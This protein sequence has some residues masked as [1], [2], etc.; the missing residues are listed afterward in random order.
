[1]DENDVTMGV[2]LHPERTWRRGDDDSKRCERVGATQ[3]RRELDKVRPPLGRTQQNDFRDGDVGPDD[4]DQDDEG[5]LRSGAADAERWALGPERKHRARHHHRDG[6]AEKHMA[7][8]EASQQNPHRQQRKGEQWKR[9][10][11][12]DHRSVPVRRASVTAAT[13]CAGWCNA[14]D[15]LSRYPMTG[16]AHSMRPR[17]EEHTSELHSLM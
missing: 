4:I 17:S 13:Y 16:P 10:E 5:E 14:D 11:A 15:V 7:G 3:G 1:M 2:M 8:R 12:A 9:D 6:G